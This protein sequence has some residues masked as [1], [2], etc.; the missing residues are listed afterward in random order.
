MATKKITTKATSSSSKKN[1][2]VLIAAAECAPLVKVGGLADIAGALPKY[3]KEEGVDARIIMPYHREIKEKYALKVKHICHFYIRLGWRTQ[4]VGL[5]KLILDKITYYL[6][7]NEFYFGSQIYCGGQFESEQYAFFSR[8]VIESYQH[9]DFKPDVIHCNDWHTA[10]IPFLIK[11]QYFAKKQGKIKTLLTIHNLHY[12]GSEPHDFYHDILDIDDMYAG[13]NYIGH[14]GKDNMLKAG[15]V[16]AD[17]VNTV[18]PTYAR[19]ICTPEQGE[20]LQGI[21]ASRGEDLFG[22][23]NGLDTKVWDPQKDKA[24]AAH[25]SAKSLWRKAKVKEDLLRQLGLKHDKEAL[26]KP[27]IAMVG[28]MTEQKG[29]DLVMA[30][31]DEIMQLDVQ[32]VMLGAGEYRFEDFFYKAERR[33]KGRLCSYLGYAGDLAHTIYAGSDLFLMPSLFEPCGISQMIAM[34]YG[35]LPIVRETGGLKDTVVPY[36]QYTGEGNGFSFS[37]YN[38]D[39]LY[40][41]VVRALDAWN[42]KKVRKQLMLQ[43]MESDFSF[44]KCAQAY[45]KTYAHL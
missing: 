9:L 13:S 2:K 44:E 8:A 25:F 36:N 27:V 41:T 35:T 22:I 37:N 12:Q 7:D 19:E 5:E 17:K 18:S 4:Y 23:L 16:Y 26:E 28:R 15:I 1:L 32:F 34:R 39:D 11:T 38:A 43:A 3:V 24:I 31:L 29:I 6:I 33:Y 14:Y 20:G 42:D 21:L 45:A 40:N 30:I 10:S